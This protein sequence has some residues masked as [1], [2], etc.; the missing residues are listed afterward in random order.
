MPSLEADD[1]VLAAV[2]ASG[3]QLQG[4][5]RLQKLIYLTS[6]ASGREAQ[7]GY[8]ANYYGPYSA[9]VAGAL[10]SQVSRQVLHEHV[11]V[12]GSR[13]PRFFGDDGEMK[14]YT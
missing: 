1:L 3:G 2:E 8:R 12:L 10:E 9:L 4:R 11:E 5:T 7:L 6:A 13:S 14:R